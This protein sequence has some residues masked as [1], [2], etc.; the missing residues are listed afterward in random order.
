MATPGSTAPLGSVTL[1]FIWAVASCAQASA[2]GIS[3]SNAT[4]VKRREDHCI[5]SSFVSCVCYAARRGAH[6]T[7][8]AR[9]RQRTSAGE[10]V[11][12]GYILPDGGRLAP[13]RLAGN[14]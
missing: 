4:S 2:D 1:P 11:A 12:R 5:T 7:P 13:R 14:I 8:A 9:G 3:S 6:D 10:P